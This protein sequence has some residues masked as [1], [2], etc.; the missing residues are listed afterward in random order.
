MI[1]KTIYKD[2]FYNFIIF[3]SIILYIL[4]FIFDE[5][6]SGSGKY[7]YYNYIIQTQKLVS[8]NIFQSII[9]QDT[10]G[11]TPLHFILYTPIYNFLGLDYL[12]L[13]NFLLS[14]VVFLIFYKILKKKISQS[15]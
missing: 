15:K 11:Y 14:F 10:S 5:D 9:S 1:G 4:G 8:Y 13:I 3:L 12:R 2:K 7:D 6:G